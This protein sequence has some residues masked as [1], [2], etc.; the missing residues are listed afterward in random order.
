MN[1]TIHAFAP[2]PAAQA[3]VTG[4]LRGLPIRGRRPALELI[5]G[6]A[7]GDEAAL[8][9]QLLIACAPG[10]PDKL[11][12]APAAKMRQGAP[13][14]PIVIVNDRDLLI[15]ASA[16]VMRRLAVAID[17]AGR[18]GAA[19][20]LLNACDQAEALASQIQRGAV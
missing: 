2:S 7:E 5:P 9:A 18:R 17:G 20:D 10:R 8:L 16:D 1:A 19:L 13:V 4:P 14:Q 15:A 11:D 3:H 12:A 6:A